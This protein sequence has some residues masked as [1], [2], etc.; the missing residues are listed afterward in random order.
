MTTKNLILGASAFALVIPLSAC[1]SSLFR[2]AKVAENQ[3]QTVTKVTSEKEEPE[4][5]EAVK[6]PFLSGEWVIKSVADTQID[7]DENYPY[8]FF[9]PE[10]NAFYASN[11]CNVLNGVYTVTADDVITFH[12][13]LTTMKY[14]A[15]TPFDTQINNVIRDENQV[16]YVYEVVDGEPCLYFNNAQGQRVMT[17]N[18]SGLDF[19]NGNWLVTDINGE[20]FDND[21]M[22]IFFDVE[23]R[24]VH[25]NTGCNSFNGEIFVDPQNKRT[26]S[27]TNMAVTMRMCPNISQQSKFLVALEQTTGARPDGRGKVY[28]TNSDGEPIMTLVAKP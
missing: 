3:G 22:T 23:E 5:V 24:K 16:K 11:G 10:E 18:K 19:L 21:E 14:C 13:V 28:L 2:K 9:V 4:S 7:R 8:I 12:N 25:G 20:E 15:D 1:A 6:T 17:L 26:F 27:L